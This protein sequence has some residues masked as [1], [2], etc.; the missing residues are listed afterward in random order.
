LQENPLHLSHLHSIHKIPN[1]YNSF[2]LQF[3]L[4]FLLHFIK[5]DFSKI[6][7]SST[8]PSFKKPQISSPPTSRVHL[9]LHGSHLQPPTL[10]KATPSSTS[11]SHASTTTQG[12]RPS[13]SSWIKPLIGPVQVSTLLTKT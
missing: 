8:N 13:S 4:F 12:L 5:R 11:P 1:L 3:T 6:P 10:P 2:H 9:G 7:I